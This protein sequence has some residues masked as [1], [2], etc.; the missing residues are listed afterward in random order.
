[1]ITIN[2]SKAA[3]E[4]LFKNSKKSKRPFTLL[5]TD[6]TLSET[7]AEYAQNATPCWQWVVHAVKLGRYVCLIAMESETRYCHVIHQVKK[8][9]IDDFIDRLNLRFMEG[10]DRLIHK[11]EIFDALE[12]SHAFERFFSDH[13]E[14]CFYS[15]TDRSVMTHINQT[16]YLYSDICAENHSLPP[17]EFSALELDLFLNQ[18]LRSTKDN[19]NFSTAYE[20]MLNYWLTQYNDFNEQQLKETAEK[21]RQINKMIWKI[22]GF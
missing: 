2:C 10:I 9:D 7:R 13:Q 19:K 3:A 8:G 16:N 12:T 11:Y 14:I 21:I 6:K 22:K 15:R 5:K 17:D 1:M 18:D 4:H 20:N